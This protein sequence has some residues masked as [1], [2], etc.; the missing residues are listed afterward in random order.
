MAGLSETETVTIAKALE[1]LFLRLGSTRWLNLFTACVFWGWLAAQPYSGAIPWLASLGF[2]L[3][4]LTLLC[5]QM[6]P[7]IDR[8]PIDNVE[9]VG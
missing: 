8:K 9:K 6:K 7:H 4:A 1:S 2:I 3:A 5:F